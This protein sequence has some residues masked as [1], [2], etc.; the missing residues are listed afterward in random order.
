MHGV[1]LQLHRN[2]RNFLFSGG[3]ASEVMCGRG[4]WED[5]ERECR[6]VFRDWPAVWLISG[7]GPVIGL[8][9][10]VLTIF[11]SRLSGSR[12]TKLETWRGE[13]LQSLGVILLWFTGL[14]SATA[15]GCDTPRG[16]LWAPPPPPRGVILFG[17]HWAYLGV[18]ERWRRFHSCRCP[19]HPV[20]KGF[21]SGG[22]RW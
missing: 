13:P 4:L 2:K 14:A 12:E 11:K 20:D 21:F 22:G 9:N 7:S 5:G 1:Q 15:P 8:P 3:S 6:F 10:V 18:R 19:Q 17:A 16:A